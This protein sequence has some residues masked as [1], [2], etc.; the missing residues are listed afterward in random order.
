M[1][2]DILLFS[3]LTGFG[4]P[5][6]VSSGGFSLGTPATGTATTQPTGFGFGFG[7]SQPASTGGVTFG[8]PAA[9]TTAATLGGLFATPASTTQAATGGSV[10]QRRY[11]FQDNYGE[12]LA[13]IKKAWVGVLHDDSNGGLLLLTL[14]LWFSIFSL[15]STPIL[16]PPI[17]RNGFY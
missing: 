16:S 12:M 4:T 10:Y 17:L 11:A 2:A 7:T 5:A 1:S 6:G 9:A 13:N 8:T 15:I 14:G 3:G